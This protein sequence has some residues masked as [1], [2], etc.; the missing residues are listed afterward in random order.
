MIDGPSSA[1][2]QAFVREHPEKKFWIISFRTPRQLETVDAELRRSGLKRACFQRIIPMP[3]RLL[4]A[5]D[6]DQLRRRVA[7][8]PGIE[9]KDAVLFPGEYRVVHWKGYVCHKI[10]ATVLVD[11]MPEY[12]LP[13]CRDYRIEFINALTMRHEAHLAETRGCTT[14]P[15][16][17]G[18]HALR[19][20]FPL[21]L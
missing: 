8:L 18:F 9:S 17:L 15:N 10:G 1:E 11:D 20:F 13:G 4:L 3:E 5:F 19:R 2:L 7:R 21:A 12:V 14:R 16:D 6:E